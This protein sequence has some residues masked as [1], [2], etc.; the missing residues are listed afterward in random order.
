MERLT[1]KPHQI[2]DFRRNKMEFQGPAERPI[3]FALPVSAAEKARLAATR[4]NPELRFHYRHVGRRRL[5]WKAAALMP[6]GAEETA[7]VLNAAGSW[8]K[9]KHEKQAD[10]FYQAIERRCPDTEI[11][12]EAVR[13]AL[14]RR[15]GRTA[16]VRR[17]PPRKAGGSVEQAEYESMRASEIL[18][19][20]RRR[21]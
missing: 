19:Q 8:L 18:S 7:D 21:E 17:K 4:L 1:G 12:K 20:V 15:A 16:G 2:E 11:G 13:K 3:S 6:D 10:R 14:V 9:D 5:A